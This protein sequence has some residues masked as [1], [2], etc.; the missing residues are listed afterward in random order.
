MNKK[1]FFYYSI[2]AIGL[3]MVDFVA[4]MPAEA[5]T[6][7]CRA[8]PLRVN[9]ANNGIF[10]PVVAN[11]EDVPCFTDSKS[12]P[13]VSL[14]G[15]LTAN[16]LVAT[17]TGGDPDTGQ[18]SNAGATVASL[19]LLGVVST[20][21]LNATAA[22]TPVN[23]SCVLSSSSSVAGLVVSG[24]PIT[25]G[26]NPLNLTIP[27][28]GILH[29]NETIKDT[30]FEGNRVTQRAVD[31]EITNVL[32]QKTLNTNRVIVAEAVADYGGNPCQ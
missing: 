11:S 10:E 6:F 31:L 25:V 28:V 18:S 29:L 20:G 5:H 14:A 30:V 2:G 4:A 19:S 7:S 26:S 9:E 22:V 15:V 3:L 17:T 21:V 12:F 1:K 27:L 24:V 32:L 16:G 23:G 8:S 13:S